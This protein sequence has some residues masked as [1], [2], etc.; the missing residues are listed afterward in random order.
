MLHRV[1]GPAV[2]FQAIRVDKD[3][4]ESTIRPVI[5]RPHRRQGC[6]VVHHNVDNAWAYGVLAQP[7]SCTAHHGTLR[8]TQPGG[9]VL[10]R[11]YLPEPIRRSLADK[12]Y[13]VV[14]L[15]RPEIT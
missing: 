5:G 9:M 8:A 7:F 3:D 14:L 6:A 10:S 4:M 1:D 13:A 2:R 12:I 11:V 15:L